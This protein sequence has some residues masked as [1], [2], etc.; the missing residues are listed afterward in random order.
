MVAKVQI[1]TTV[2]ADGS[3]R[4]LEHEIEVAG[5][6]PGDRIQE[7]GGDRPGRR[8]YNQGRPVYTINVRD[9]APYGVTVPQ[10]LPSG[11]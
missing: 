7:P 2:A 5:V 3:V 11:S 10:P 9:F 6:R 4:L 8:A 1:T